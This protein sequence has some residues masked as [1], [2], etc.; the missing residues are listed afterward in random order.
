[1][2]W[3][4]VGAAAVGVVGSAIANRGNKSPDMAAA[5]Q[6]Q[7][8]QNIEAAREQ[9]AMNNPNIRT[10]FGSQTWT[11]AATPG[12]R[13]TMTQTLSPDEQWIYDQRHKLDSAT[14]S[15]MMEA[16]PNVV[17]GIMKP[18]GIAEKPMMGLDE[19]F[20]PQPGDIQRNANWGSAGNIQSGLDYSGAPGMPVASDETRRA[21]TDAVYRQGA[22]FLDPQFKEQQDAMTTALANQGMTQ[23]GVGAQRAQDAYDRARTLA[24]GDLGDRATQQG[25]A[26]MDK[27]FGEQLAARSQ[28]V[29]E[30]TKAGEFANASQLQGINE[31]IATMNARN[32]AATTGANIGALSTGAW[33]A[34]Q[35]Q[36]YN[37]DIT[38]RT[39]PVNL[40]EAMLTHGQVNN[41]QFQPMAPTTITPPP[42]FAGAQ[43]QGQVNAANATSNNQLVGGLV[44]AGLNYYGKIN[45]PTGT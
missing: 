28:G 40:Y 15:A 11:E 30:I 4:L 36:A 19:R 20:M 8:Q 25:I 14:N 13:A 29:G 6:Q 1:M 39:T 26:A 43:A 42:T 33:N 41:P 34:G 9:A 10:P 17:G 45:S 7:G 22:R 21:V 27:L 16:F 2:T 38:N 31:L 24:Y 5:A 35:G 37:Q 18:F 3:A 23:G 44:N 32:N 12:G